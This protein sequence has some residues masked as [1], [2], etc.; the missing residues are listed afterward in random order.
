MYIHIRNSHCEGNCQEQWQIS[1]KTPEGQLNHKRESSM[2]EGIPL[3]ADCLLR[4][5]GL[6]A[7]MQ[8][9]RYHCVHATLV[10]KCVTDTVHE[11]PGKRFWSGGIQ[12]TLQYTWLP[13]KWA[14][15]VSWNRPNTGT[16]PLCNEGVLMLMRTFWL[17]LVRSSHHGTQVNREL[18]YPLG[19]VRHLQQPGGHFSILHLVKTSMDIEFHWCHEHNN[20][21][22]QTKRSGL[23]CII[24]RKLKISHLRL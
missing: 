19:E 15:V 6:G 3:R 14:E 18:W 10:L 17:M 9:A 1:T 4:R 2:Q 20:K 12:Q 16:W 24:E 13:T 22:S 11:I 8:H 21:M 7:G 23:Y 5:H